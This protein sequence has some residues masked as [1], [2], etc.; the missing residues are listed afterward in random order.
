MKAYIVFPLEPEHGCD[1]V[2]AETSKRAKQ[3]GWKMGAVKDFGDWTDVRVRR[4]PGADRFAGEFEGVV[5]NERVQ[6]E[7][8]FRDP[9]ADRACAVCGLFSNGL[10]NKRVCGNCLF[11]PDC[12]HDPECFSDGA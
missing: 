8:G 1:L 12:G 2:F 6:R 9:I 10:P 3:V 5:W 4:A 11:C 7:A